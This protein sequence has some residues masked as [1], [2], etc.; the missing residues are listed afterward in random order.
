MYLFH[1]VLANIYSEGKGLRSEQPKQGVAMAPHALD[2]ERQEAGT[3][4][5]A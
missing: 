3:A 1:G 2:N 5:V 4:E